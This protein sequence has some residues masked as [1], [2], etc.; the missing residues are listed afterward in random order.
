MTRLIPSKMDIRFE[1]LIDDEEEDSKAE[2]SSDNFTPMM[3]N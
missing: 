2:I 1:E 3:V